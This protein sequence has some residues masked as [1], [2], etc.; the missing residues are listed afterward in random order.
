M[1]GVVDGEVPPGP[2][3]VV[4][5]ELLTGGFEVV[6]VALCAVVDVVE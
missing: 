2:V 5:E 1:A 3:V 6:V 4:V